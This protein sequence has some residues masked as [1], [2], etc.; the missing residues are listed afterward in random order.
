MEA[1]RKWIWAA[2]AAAGLMAVS[3]ADARGFRRYF[4]MKEEIVG[5]EDRNQRLSQN[6]QKLVHEI[7]ALRSNP[8]A[9]E[10][11]AREELGYVKPNEIIL[12]LE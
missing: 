6:N 4:K 7:N 8:A 11:A 1:R 12:N 2:V 3:V 10:R 5:L 9:L